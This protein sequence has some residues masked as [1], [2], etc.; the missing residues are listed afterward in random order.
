MI[1]G[2]V[3]AAITLAVLYIAGTTLGVSLTGGEWVRMTVLILVGLLPFAALGIVDR[4]LLTPDSI[5]PAMGGATA[6]FALLGGTWFPITGGV[7]QKIG[8]ALPSYWLVQAG[9]VGLGGKGW[10]TTGWVVIAVWARRRRDRRRALGLPARHEA[11]L[12]RLG[13]RRRPAARAPARARRRPRRA[14]SRRRT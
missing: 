11:G 12:A 14:P 1:T 9:H 7:M 5:G 8:E 4:A 13:W 2:Y 6:L 3:M 10:S